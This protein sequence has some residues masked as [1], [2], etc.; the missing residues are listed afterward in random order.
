MHYVACM[1]QYQFIY[2]CIYINKFYIF[3]LTHLHMHACTLHD[4]FMQLLYLCLLDVQNYTMLGSN[5]EFCTQM[6]TVGA[7]MLRN[8]HKHINQC[9]MHGHLLNAWSMWMWIMLRHA[10]MIVVYW[11]KR[12]WP[13]IILF[14]KISAS[15][16]G[17]PRSRVCTRETLHSAPHQH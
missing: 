5:K 9:M 14:G 13:K 4:A 16:D 10:W 1:M 12:L 7:Y 11:V 2:D 17:G 3:S 6:I 8:A 15:A